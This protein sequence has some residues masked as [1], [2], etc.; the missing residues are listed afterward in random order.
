MRARTIIYRDAP[1]WALTTV[2]VADVR[3]WLTSRGV[4]TVFFFPGESDASNY[5]NAKHPRYARRLAAAVNAWLA[6][7]QAS[8]KSVKDAI[9]KWLREHA[10][11]YELTNDDG[12]PNETGIEE[13]AKVANWQPTGG[14]PKTPGQ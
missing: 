2:A 8:D 4:T 10:A 12:N 9:K 6:V 11:E 13:V 14:A 7:T 3:T 5:L 1:D